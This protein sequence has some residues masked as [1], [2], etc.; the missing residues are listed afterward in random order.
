MRRGYVQKRNEMTNIPLA[1]LSLGGLEGWFRYLTSYCRLWPGIGGITERTRAVR[2][3][4]LAKGIGSLERARGTKS[5]CT[6]NSAVVS[7]SECT[8]LYTLAINSSAI[9]VRL[10]LEGVWVKQCNGSW[11]ITGGRYP[12]GRFHADVIDEIYRRI[13]GASLGLHS[14]TFA[15]QYESSESSLML[16]H[17]CTTRTYY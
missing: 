13:A 15:N 7:G 6:G 8:V 9:E 3:R 1:P 11:L 16:K 10:G 5:K 12:V 17:T 2:L 14:E 4:D